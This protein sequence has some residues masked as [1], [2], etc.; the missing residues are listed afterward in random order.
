MTCY[1]TIQFLCVACGRPET[2]NPHTVPSVRTVH[3]H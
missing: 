2:A 3:S 1:A